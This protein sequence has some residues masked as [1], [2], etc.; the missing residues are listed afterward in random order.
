MR[1]M[2]QKNEIS[3][4]KHCLQKTKR[5]R[6][7]VAHHVPISN[8]ILE[9]ERA[10]VQSAI[11]TLEAAIQKGAKKYHINQVNG[12]LKARRD[13]K[14]TSDQLVSNCSYRDDNTKR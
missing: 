10:V 14:A 9:K 11:E 8:H 7:M 3:N 5:V 4:L 6:N 13:A 2:L 12:P 1:E